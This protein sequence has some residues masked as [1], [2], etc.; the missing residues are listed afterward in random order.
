MLNR[1]AI[2]CVALQWDHLLY[3]YYYPI[4]CQFP[5]R[6]VMTS[7]EK[8]NR[9]RMPLLCEYTIKKQLNTKLIGSV[10]HKSVRCLGFLFPWKKNS[11]KCILQLAKCRSPP[12][13]SVRRRRRRHR[14]RRRH[15]SLSFL[16][17]NE[18]DVSRHCSIETC[19]HLTR[20]FF[21]CDNCFWLQKISSNGGKT[22]LIFLSKST[23]Q[24]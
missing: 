16:L 22:R 13:P 8:L 24:T 19:H 1:V 6:F 12:P 23:V 21:F 7:S 2:L 11:S 5:P 9:R 15:T 20:F 3:D 17:Q 14:L 18:L 4:F 10:L